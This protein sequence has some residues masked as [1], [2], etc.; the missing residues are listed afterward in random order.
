MRP[1]GVGA[2]G[3]IFASLPGKLVGVPIAASLFVGSSAIKP[4][5]AFMSSEYVPFSPNRDAILADLQQNVTLVSLTIS[6][7]SLVVIW[8]LSVI[9][10]P[11]YKVAVYFISGKRCWGPSLSYFVVRGA[12]GATLIGALLVSFPIWQPM[13]QS[14]IQPDVEKMDV[15][16]MACLALLSFIINRFQKSGDEGIA[17]LIGGSS[18]KNAAMMMGFI[19]YLALIVPTFINFVFWI[20][21]RVHSIF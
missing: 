1:H 9:N 11:Y 19:I 6:L 17:S 3:R 10:W 7:L 5:M 2:W 21:L 8:L 12:S 15:L 13:L 14:S 16:G 20:G 4:F 18:L